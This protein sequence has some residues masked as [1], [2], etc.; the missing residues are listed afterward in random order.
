MRN[1]Q[2]KSNFWI[3]LT[4]AISSF[5]VWA[6]VS[7]SSWPEQTKSRLFLILFSSFFWVPAIA[8]L[9]SGYAWKNLAPG[10]RGNH[11][12]EE[13]TRYWL[14]IIGYAIGACVM[15]LLVVWK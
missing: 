4:I 14:A 5:A 10:N 1:I 9:R 2:P 15:I 13:P 7:E 8:V 12:S 11:K 6:L 3:V